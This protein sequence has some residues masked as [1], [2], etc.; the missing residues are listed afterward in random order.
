MSWR[1]WFERARLDPA[2][3]GR[4]L[5]FTDSIVMLGAAIAGLG[6]A[7]GRDKHV[8]PQLARGELIRV[9]QDGWL[10]EWSYFLVAPAAHI[11]RPAVRE[12]VDWALAEA[13]ASP[14]GG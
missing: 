1:A 3:A 13:K 4:G 11:Q 9:T 10:A 7:L 5:Q 12:F 2:P 6:I 8:A 14:A